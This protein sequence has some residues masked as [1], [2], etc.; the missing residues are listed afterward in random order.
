MHLRPSGLSGV[1]GGS[2]F[3]EPHP[4]LS[5]RAA[6]DPLGDAASSAC[7]SKQQAAENEQPTGLTQQQAL[8]DCLAEHGIPR[9]S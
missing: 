1:R 6:S 7:G 8:A 2:T 5:Y 3:G 4:R 9:R